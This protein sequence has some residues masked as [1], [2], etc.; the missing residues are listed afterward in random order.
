M[1]PQHVANFGALNVVT[2][3]SRETFQFYRRI[4][5]WLGQ[6]PRG[7]VRAKAVKELDENFEIRIHSMA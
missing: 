3:T 7:N 1:N 4:R 6:L 2:L 5:M